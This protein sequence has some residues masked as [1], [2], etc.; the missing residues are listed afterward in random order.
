M[1]GLEYFYQWQHPQ[2]RILYKMATRGVRVDSVFCEDLAQHTEEKMDA[3]AATLPEINWRSP[4][5]VAEYLY[6]ELGLSLPP[7]KGTMK[8][9]S[10]CDEGERPTADA[11]LHWLGGV[12]SDHRDM[13]DRARE[14]KKLGRLKSFAESLP[15][16]LV[17]DRV[18]PILSAKT[19]T[20]RLAC[21]TPALQQQP[22]DIRGAFVPTPGYV[23]ICRDYSA[24]EWRILAHILMYRYGDTSLLDDVKAG[25][26]PH[27]ATAVRMF[28]LG[29]SP[30]EVKRLYHTHREIGKTLNYCV[31]EDTTA[32]TPSGWVTHD[33]L[34]PGSKVLG[35]NGWT[36]VKKV[37][38]YEN[39]DLFDMWGFH[40]TKNHRW[41]GD[42]RTTQGGR[43]VRV[44]EFVETDAFTSDHRALLSV[45][46]EWS[47]S[48]GCT[49][50]EL[51]LATWI[52]TDGHA[53]NTV[54]ISQKKLPFVTEIDNL[55]QRLNVSYGKSTRDDGVCTWWLHSPHSHRYRELS[56]ALTEEFV[57]TM[58]PAHRAAFVETF[59]KAE[60]CLTYPRIK[61]SQNRGPLA[62]AIRLALFLEGHYVSQ[63]EST[64]KS[65]NQ[66]L[67]LI[68]SSPYK[69]RQRKPLEK[70]YKGFSW[71]VETE[72]GTFVIRRGDRIALTGNSIN[73]GKTAAGLGWQIR[74]EHGNAIGTERAQEYLDMF[75]A[76]NPGIER[77]HED[78]KKIAY[79]RGYVTSLLGRR[80]YLK[81]IRSKV[82]WKRRAEERRALNV[83]QD[84]AAD[85]VT[86]AMVVADQCQELREMGTHLLLQIHDELLFETPE[87]TEE[88]A[89]EIITEIMDNS[90]KRTREFCCPL[91][92]SGG[93]VTSWGEGH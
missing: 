20:G 3:L 61:L 35:R 86:V 37:F 47:D 1:D 23:M 36:T 34:K 85:I 40:V 5:Q 53:G 39:T 29:C 27:G 49:P 38:R 87:G 92:T 9:V 81:N 64:L 28:N 71:C 50:D 48:S 52:A 67:V 66:H 75:Y 68:A 93:V 11:S 82:G 91:N 89:N 43:R 15:K 57:L 73:Y 6:D 33:K 62:E 83:I 44:P 78:I 54:S 8:A 10:I 70:V 69:T 26:D 79:D 60:G 22:P 46:Q 14:W 76:G 65:G 31:S 32:L 24:L 56:K 80:R 72:D 25:L 63:Y 58:G 4:K 42:R 17:G 88:K 2:D 7:V 77:F 21:S 84:C 41:W 45:K 51:R 55:L 30:N 18:H 59:W 19:K 74:D 12:H 13:I 90:F 16:H